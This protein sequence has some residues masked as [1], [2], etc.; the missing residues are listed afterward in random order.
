MGELTENEIREASEAMKSDLYNA[1][2][3]LPAILE[4]RFLSSAFDG[5]YIRDSYEIKL[6]HISKKLTH[7]IVL[8]YDVD[9]DNYGIDAD[10]PDGEL[11]EV[12][13]ENIMVH[14]Y[15]DVALNTPEKA[16][17]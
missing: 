7:K 4:S 17:G 11:L 9:A 13:P 16:E 1:M 6:E 8:A 15:F 12:S 10:L 14:L 2:Y 5:W 3:Q